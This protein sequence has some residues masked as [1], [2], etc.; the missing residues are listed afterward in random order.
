MS[1]DDTVD[2]AIE[3]RTYT[4]ARRFPL[5]VGQIGGYYLPVPWT[6]PQLLTAFGTFLL[7]LTTRRV[8]A[9]FGV[10]VNIA[11][12]V[13]LPL[14]LSWLVRYLRVEGRSTARAAAGFARYLSR[15]RTGKLHGRPVPRARAH[16]RRPARVFV[17]HAAPA[18]RPAAMPSPPSAYPPSSTGG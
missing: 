10:V 13:S 5:V 2:D 14:A 6:P 16:R 8:W 12:L 11:I 3:C 4:H 1:T 17:T 7:L 15:S 18:A 9:H